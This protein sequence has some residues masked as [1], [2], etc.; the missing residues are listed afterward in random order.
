MVRGAGAGPIAGVGPS[1][2]TAAAEPRALAKHAKAPDSKLTLVVR[3]FRRI[4]QG[5]VGA[6]R[7]ACCYMRSTRGKFESDPTRLS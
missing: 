3:G 4:L 7:D 1:L 2:R 5:A 6:A